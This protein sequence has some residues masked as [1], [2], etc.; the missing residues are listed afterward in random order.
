MLRVAVIGFGKLGLLHAGLVNALPGSR[1][2]AVVDSDSRTLSVL[3]ARMRGVRFYKEH[4]KLLQDGDIDAAVIATPTGLHIDVAVDC[5]EAGVPIFIEKP[6]AA[7]AAQARPLIEALKR[8]PVANMCGYMG[9]YAATFG[10][11]KEIVDSGALGRPQML[12]SSMYIAQLFAR[13]KGWRY[14]KAA[15]GGGVL[16]TQNSHL[17]DK[18]TWLFGDV[19]YVS[20][21]TR[22]LYSAE[23]ED[24]AHAFLSFKSGL[25]GYLDASWSA[26]HYRTPTISIHM[27][28]EG[29]TLDVDDD[30]VSVFVDKKMN[31]IAEGRTIWRKPDLFHGVAFD[32][33]G[34]QYS[35]QMEAF[36]RAASGGGGVDSDI[37]SAY[38]VQLVLEAMYRSA[39]NKGEPIRPADLAA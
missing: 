39:A 14:D 22:S 32:I 2:E 34:P 38:K 18:L 35:N 33:G 17:I 25:S 26:R 4:R 13:G 6:L 16:I 10:K 37:D 36:I 23:V 24:Y 12:R 29:G 20:A 1:L 11:A 8:R 31:G 7:S 21:Q 5:V 27:Q 28:G 3:K 15:S 9:R 30:S 19:D